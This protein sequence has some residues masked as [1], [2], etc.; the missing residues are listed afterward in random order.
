MS[1]NHW[2]TILTAHWHVMSLA[3]I[4][5]HVAFTG[6]RRWATRFYST[7]SE[8]DLICGAGAAATPGHHVL[9]SLIFFYALAHANLNINGLAS[10]PVPALRPPEP[11][12][13]IP[14]RDCPT[15]E[16]RYIPSREWPC[17]AF[18][19]SSFPFVSPSYHHDH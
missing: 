13:L 16:Q 5:F 1:L 9:L 18:V 7:D 19:C 17:Q 15:F 2:W 8:L 10:T 3:M 4:F 12:S 11:P 6:V 14:A